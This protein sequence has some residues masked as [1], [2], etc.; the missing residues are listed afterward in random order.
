MGSSSAD[1][2]YTLTQTNPGVLWESSFSSL[3]E[4]WKETTFKLS[5]YCPLICVLCLGSMFMVFFWFCFF[6]VCVVCLFVCFAVAVL[7]LLVS[8]SGLLTFHLLLTSSCVLQTA[9]LVWLVKTKIGAIFP[10]LKDET[11]LTNEISFWN[12]WAKI[13]V[14]MLY[15]TTCDTASWASS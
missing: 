15:V 13:Y 12:A 1:T 8:S 9:C 5:L 7:I 2:L 14:M 10:E 6:C 3:K 4:I 11:L